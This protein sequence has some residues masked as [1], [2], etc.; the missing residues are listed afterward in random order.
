M[1]AG[2]FATQ[3][4]QK[5]PGENGD[6][7][8]HESHVGT[9]KRHTAP[10]TS[11]RGES[12]RETVIMV[13][14]T[15]A[16][17]LRRESRE[18]RL[19][20]PSGH[21]A[22]KGTARSNV[23]AT[24]SEHSRKRKYGRQSGFITSTMPVVHKRGRMSRRARAYAQTC[25]TRGPGSRGGAATGQQQPPVVVVRPA[26]LFGGG[27]A[28]SWVGGAGQRRPARAQSLRL[29]DTVTDGAPYG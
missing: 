29:E 9:T 12:G 11:R 24:S 26:T 3:P 27:G 18:A 4:F 16:Q 21:L 8:P 5:T 7:T 2:N 20:P 28:G 15:Q 13:R 6:T 22:F 17:Y 14:P 23:K 25:I 1:I 19:S 10:G